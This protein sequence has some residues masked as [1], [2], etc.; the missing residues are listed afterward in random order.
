VSAYN[1]WEEDSCRA[2]K[3]FDGE[4]A[5]MIAKKEKLK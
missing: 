5:I 1:C 3:F 4:N 2:G